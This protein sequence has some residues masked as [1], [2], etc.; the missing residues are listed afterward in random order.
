MGDSILQESIGVTAE[1]VLEGVPVEVENIGLVLLILL[2][3][4]GLIRLLSYGYTRLKV[5]L[6]ARKQKFLKPIYIKDYPILSI[7][8]EEKVVF[9]ILNIF[10][11]LLIFILIY[12][13]VGLIFGIFPATEGIAMKLFSYIWDP[14]KTIIHS[15]INFIP[16]VFIIIIIWFI[17]RYVIKG[18]G[19]LS[20]EITLERLK[21]TGFYPD[22]A[23][24]T[25][26]IIRFILNALM[27]VMIWPY[28]PMSDSSIF[29][30]MT[31]FIG[32]IM[33][34]ASGPALGNLIAG[35]IITY[36]RSFQMGDR[37][38]INDM[39]GN[40]IERTP[41]VTRI[42]TIKNE[43]ITIPNT[44]IMTAQ[45]TNLSESARENNG[46]IIHLNVTFSY[47]T[48]WR[49]IHELLIGAALKT[50]NVLQTPPP[51]V[52]E[53]GFNDFYVEYEIN[54]YIADANKIPA[55]FSD[56]RSNIQDAFHTAGISMTSQHYQKLTKAG[57][58]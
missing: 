36:M 45:S 54:V 34:F 37:I 53:V 21:I 49:T 46:L 24:P 6:D 18:I 8:T 22:W 50:E 32:V 26:G 20:N 41:I 38:Q 29:Q 3:L 1:G 43:I 25:F 12:I 40:V 47:E 28:L 15:I 17:F 58:G 23:Q 7:S 44:N 27:V 4:Y 10:R 11:Y 16:N 31:V 57:N 33:S 35:I 48:P 14:L 19:Y 5:F 55:I 52:L 42:R 2:V 51:F 39:I 9:F 56:L 13:A 30:G